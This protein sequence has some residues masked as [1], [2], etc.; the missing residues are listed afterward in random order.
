MELE[1][2]AHATEHKHK[3]RKKQQRPAPTGHPLAR[4]QKEQQ[5]ALLDETHNKQVI[6]VFLPKNK[7]K[8]RGRRCQAAASN[9]TAPI[10]ISDPINSPA[11][12]N[13]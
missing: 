4:A 3:K 1:V 10:S 2:M 6:D 7:S 12:S 8:W 5:M 9:C 13:L 11:V